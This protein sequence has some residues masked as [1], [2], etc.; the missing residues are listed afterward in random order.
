M[1]GA[2]RGAGARTHARAATARARGLLDQNLENRSAA[3][4]SQPGCWLGR[5]G[6]RSSCRG[7]LYALYA[8]YAGRSGPHAASGFGLSLVS[9]CVRQS[10][11]GAGASCV[12]L[13]RASGRKEQRCDIIASWLR[14]SIEGCISCTQP[15]GALSG[16]CPAH[17][18]RV[19]NVACRQANT[20]SVSLARSLARSRSRSVFRLQCSPVILPGQLHGNDL[21]GR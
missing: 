16:C 10:A 3:C 6:W 19:S 8:L 4:T 20:N 14:C 1:A 13:F 15:P 7:A 18:P 11:R 17:R 9:P 5:A 21:L 2:R 12:V